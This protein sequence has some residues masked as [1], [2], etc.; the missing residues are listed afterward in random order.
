VHTTDPDGGP[1]QTGGPIIASTAPVPSPPAGLNRRSCGLVNTR[2][3]TSQLISSADVFTDDTTG[4][5]QDS[6]ITWVPGLC[7]PSG[8]GPNCDMAFPLY[9]PET[10]GGTLASEGMTDMKQVT[11]FSMNSPGTVTDTRLEFNPNESD[12]YIT[13]AKNCG[14]TATVVGDQTRLIRTAE[15]EVYEYLEVSLQVAIGVVFDHMALT[16]AQRQAIFDVAVR[17]GQG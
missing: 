12:L 1:T 5:A 4:G 6:E 8:L 16:A 14:A 7:I 13:D 10:I 2:P 11:I 15:P 9:S 17:R 3:D